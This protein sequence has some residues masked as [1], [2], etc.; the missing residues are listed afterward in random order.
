MENNM[1]VLFVG[2]GSPMNVIEDNEF[3]I[4]DNLGEKFCHRS[5]RYKIDTL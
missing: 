4:F 5:G 3:V 2:H 1:P